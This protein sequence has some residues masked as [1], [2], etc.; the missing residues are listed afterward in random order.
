MHAYIV[1]KTHV[2]D[3]LRFQ[4]LLAFFE[5]LERESLEDIKVVGFIINLLRIY[6]GG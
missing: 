6:T 5:E 2:Y 1:Y 3:F 4:R